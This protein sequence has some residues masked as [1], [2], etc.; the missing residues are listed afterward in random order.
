MSCVPALGF[1]IL[2]WVELPGGHFD[3]PEG[4][5]NMFHPERIR[6]MHI[7]DDIV[8]CITRLGLLRPL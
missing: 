3:H 7:I 2:Y 1:I 6:G 4:T 8:K 5:F